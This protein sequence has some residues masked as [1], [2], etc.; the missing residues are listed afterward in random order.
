MRKRFAFLSLLLLALALPLCAAS[1]AEMLQFISRSG[2]ARAE[3][4][5][6]FEETRAMPRKEKVV[7][8]G[9]LLYRSPDFLD[10]Q[11]ENPD[12]EHFKIEGNKMV[13]RRGG[14]E[15]KSD[16]T[17]N[18]L[19]RRLSH[20][21]LYAFSGQVEKISTEQNTTLQVSELKD[22]YC[23]VLDARKK[24]PMGYCHIE[25]HYRKSDGQIVFMQM[26]EFNGT[27]TI[28]ALAE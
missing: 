12:K 1:E 4:S 15:I 14:L 19:M 6:P 26:D 13:N 22:E 24:Q 11:Y 3:M 27:S 28:Y 10:M 16:L 18:V 2:E 20:T 8:R 5:T 7:L 23:V 25:I 21:L 9:N 17:K